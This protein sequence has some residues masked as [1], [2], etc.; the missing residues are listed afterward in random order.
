MTDFTIIKLKKEG[1]LSR[2]DTISTPQLGTCRVI[3]IQSINTIDV[4]TVNGK[5]Y[6]LSGVCLGPDAR[7]VT[8]N[9][10]EK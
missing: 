9:E 8:L 4:E 3:A 5:N 1:S 6:R 10:A 7:I 2:G